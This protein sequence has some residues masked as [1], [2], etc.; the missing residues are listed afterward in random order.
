LF[1]II[2]IA[3]VLVSHTALRD[4]RALG[5]LPAMSIPL[6]IEVHVRLI[7]VLAPASVRISTVLRSASMASFDTTR[8]LLAVRSADSLSLSCFL[9]L[10]GSLLL[11]I[12][13]SSFSLT[14]NLLSFLFMVELVFSQVDDFII[15]HNAS[16]VNEGGHLW[17][18]DSSI[19][20]ALLRQVDL[21]DRLNWLDLRGLDLDEQLRVVSLADTLDLAQVIAVVGRGQVP[22]HDH[23]VLAG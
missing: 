13:L 3:T 10:P 17:P 7:R 2:L 16:V 21:M 5:H 15:C 6:L 23:A 18:H 22:P 1:L 4:L 14:L 8:P 11:C 9:L 12:F 19:N 20:L